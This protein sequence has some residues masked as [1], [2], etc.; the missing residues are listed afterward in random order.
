MKPIQLWLPSLTGGAARPSRQRDLQRLKN[1][2]DKHHVIWTVPNWGP[3]A[4]WLEDGLRV[5]CIAGE[6]IERF[7]IIHIGSNYVPV[8]PAASVFDSVGVAELLA[9]WMKAEVSAVRSDGSLISMK[10]PERVPQGLSYRPAALQPLSG[11]A[12]QVTS[13]DDEAKKFIARWPPEISGLSPISP[14]S[15]AM[16]MEPD[17]NLQTQ[18]I[19]LHWPPPFDDMMPKLPSEDDLFARDLLRDVMERARKDPKGAMNIADMHS[20]SWLDDGLSNVN[21][22]WLQ[23]IIV[24]EGN[25]GASFAINARFDVDHWDLSDAYQDRN[26]QAELKRPMGVRRAIGIPGLAWALL[27]DF[28]AQGRSARNCDLCGSP[29]TGRSHKRYCSESDN[30]DCFRRRK[31]ADRRRARQS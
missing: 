16:V 20:A 28:F 19:R 4:T 30:S 6:E 11:G 21:L 26:V 23:P 5:G 29:I 25:E 27:L 18:P 24:K 15:E 13:T 17:Q 2:W 9:E 3:P 31:N 14:Q 12:F 22:A 7:R 1:A 10:L 8:G